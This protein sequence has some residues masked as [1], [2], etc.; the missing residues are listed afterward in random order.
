LKLKKNSKVFSI[1]WVSTKREEY[2]VLIYLNILILTMLTN[3]EIKKSINIK[4]K[5][6]KIFFESRKLI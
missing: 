2:K 6:F 4:M 5:S 3:K 1:N